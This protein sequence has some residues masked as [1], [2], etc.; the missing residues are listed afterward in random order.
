MHSLKS[1][2]DFW[3]NSSKD[4]FTNTSHFH[5]LYK[6]SIPIQQKRM[7]QGQA[8]WLK[9]RRLSPFLTL[10]E[11]KE[12][13]NRP[14]PMRIIPVRTRI[15]RGHSESTEFRKMGWVPGVIMG[16][17]QPNRYIVLDPRF[18]HSYIDSGKGFA[19]RDFWLEIDKG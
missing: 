15:E 12:I 9:N 6:H 11:I 14:E 3:I 19:H 2:R 1:L 10:E 7:V 18:I 13:K 16:Q 5:S 17:K 4:L 8:P